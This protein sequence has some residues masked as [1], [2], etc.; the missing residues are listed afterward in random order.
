MTKDREEIRN[1]PEDSDSGSGAHV[2]NFKIRPSHDEDDK[3]SVNAFVLMGGR[4]GTYY[5]RVTSDSVDRGSHHVEITQIDGDV[6]DAFEFIF[7]G[8]APDGHME[9]VQVIHETYIGPVQD[10]YDYAVSADEAGE[11]E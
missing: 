6:L 4:S 10:W 11:S 7:P 2:R 1:S 3:I 5:L 8:T 9:A